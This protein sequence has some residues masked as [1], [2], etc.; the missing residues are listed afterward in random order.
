[1][2]N[3]RNPQLERGEVRIE[4]IKLN[5]K[6][7]DD[8]LALLSEL[9]YLYTQEALRGRLLALMDEFILLG[10]NKKVGRPGMAMLSILVMGVVKQG[11][12]CDFDRLYDLANQHKT[13][14]NFLGHTDCD[15]KLYHYQTLVDNVSLLTPKLLGK[16]N[17]LIVESGHTV[18]GKKPGA[19]LRGS[20]DSFVVETNVHYPTDVSLLRD[21]MSCMLHRS[22]PL[23][24]KHKVPKW[25]QWMHL[26]KTLKEKFN[27][28][29]KTLSSA[30]PK[31]IKAFLRR[32]IHF[33]Q[34]V[35]YSHKMRWQSMP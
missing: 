32:L 21:A 13:L 6:S 33:V 30:S 3:L 5:H 17:Q 16:V 23:G 14:R 2:R 18:V 31:K 35:L 8:M 11:L 29:R 20:C 24:S 7:R 22:G 26:Q 9:Q 4:D 34:L 12:S 1:M 19:P 27:K 28:V 15:K 10:V 25:R